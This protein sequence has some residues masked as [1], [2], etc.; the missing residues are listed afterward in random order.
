MTD[1]PE[2]TRFPLA[3]PSH[4]ARTPWQQ[5]RA[6][7]FRQDGHDITIA[8]AMKRID[9][10]LNRMNA[11]YPL[12]STNKELRADGSP[13]SDRGEP[14]DPGVCVYFHL[15][16]KPFAMACDTYYGVAMNLAA[17]AA[18]L[19]ATRA[20]ERYGVATAAETLQAF[21]ALPPPADVKPLRPWWEVLGILRDGADRESVEAMYRAKARKCHPDVGGSAEDMADLNRA[22]NEG[23]AE[24]K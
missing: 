22:R 17:V 7:K 3:W 13:R 21:T 9:L 18:H 11:S 20:I 23:L 2:P 4:K 14:I 6:G 10:E 8:R 5:R 16:G 1:M 24:A 12:V 15:K 19:G